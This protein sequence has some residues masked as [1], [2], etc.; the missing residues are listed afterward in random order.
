MA[1]GVV[2]PPP[3]PRNTSVERTR[4]TIPTHKTI[5]SGE[6]LGVGYF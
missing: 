2:I 5:N 3:W 1:M 6:Y 4:T